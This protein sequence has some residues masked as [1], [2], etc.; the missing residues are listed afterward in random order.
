MPRYVAILTP[1]SPALAR[2]GSSGR[3]QSSD[4]R[5]DLARE[6]VEVCESRSRSVVH[7]GH[8]DTCVSVRDDVSETGGF[9]ERICRDFR[10]HPMLG[11]PLERRSER[12][13]RPLTLVRYDVTRDIKAV[14]DGEHEVEGDQIPRVATR[15]A[16]SPSLAMTTS[17]S[18]TSCPPGRQAG[19]VGV[20]HPLEPGAVGVE[21]EERAR[22]PAGF[23][24]GHVLG[25]DD[26]VAHDGCQERVS[27]VR[28]IHDVHLSFDGEREIAGERQTVDSGRLDS[29]IDI[30]IVAR[31]SPCR[32]PEEHRQMHVAPVREYTPQGLDCSRRHERVFYA[33]YGSMK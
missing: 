4:P 7:E 14:L 27:R 6:R 11:E 13:R 8:V 20:T 12:R 15:S 22:S 17:R 32:R 30:G 3:D 2:H 19:E 25:N 9:A 23:G 18:T 21:R 31:R 28:Q 33:N 5:G 29:Q 26:A 10:Q 1:A 24:A 16:S